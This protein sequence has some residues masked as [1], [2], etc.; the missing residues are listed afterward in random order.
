MFTKTTK[1]MS[2]QTPREKSRHG[3]TFTHSL[4][5]SLTHALTHSHCFRS[6]TCKDTAEVRLSAAKYLKQLND[7]PQ[8]KSSSSLQSLKLLPSGTCE[9][10]NRVKFLIQRNSPSDFREGMLCSFFDPGRGEWSSRGM[11]M[12][13]ITLKDGKNGKRLL[14]VCSTGH[15]ACVLLCLEPLEHCMCVVCDQS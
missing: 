15:C 8:E 9:I 10:T 5:H 4:T 14:A 11:F 2:T 1:I 3:R 12:L 13:G 6:V 7:G